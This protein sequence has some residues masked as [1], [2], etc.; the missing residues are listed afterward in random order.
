MKPINSFL[1]RNMIYKAERFL[2]TSIKPKREKVVILGCG[3]GGYRLAKDID[4][5]KFD[6]TLV[7]PRN[8]F[9]FTPLLPSTSV[10]TLEFRCIQEPIRAVKGLHYH[11]A[12][13][14]DLD[15]QAKT[16]TC[17]DYFNEGDKF[18]LSYDMLVV[19]TGSETNTFGVHGVYGNTSVF[20]LKQLSD[21][22]AIRNRLI[23]CFERASIPSTSPEEVKRLLTF[24][25][26]GGGPTNVEFAAE[27]HDFV[28]DDVE[29]LYPELA[30]KV[31]LTVIEAAGHILGAFTESLVG[32]VEGLFKSRNIEVLTGSLVQSVNGSSAVIKH[33]NTNTQEVLKFGLMVWST[34][35]QQIPLIREIPLEYK[36]KNGRLQIDEHLRLLK[37]SAS[38]QFTPIPGVYAIGDCAGHYEKPLAAL[39]Q[40]ANQQGRYLAQTVSTLIGVDTTLTTT[41]TTFNTTTSTDTT[42]TTTNTTTSPD[43]TLDSTTT[44]TTTDTNT[45]PPFK[46]AHLGSMASVGS[47]K[48]VLDT[49]GVDGLPDKMKGGLSGF[50]AFILWRAVYFSKQVSFTNMLLI[51][52]YWFKSAVLGRDISRF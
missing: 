18:T 19:S 4:K 46:Y 8:H 35:L 52:M 40:V 1:A 12:Y 44:D 37:T 33:N 20:F 16:V 42:T 11:Q 26:V 10:G 5:E 27:L 31:R 21:A 22:R 7:S 29:K 17:E 50:V 48:G 49:T 6:V 23:E 36:L 28:K 13:A 9:L 3:W 41:D 43:S 30:G 14:Q 34:G 15:F 51:P 2:A 32:Y 39:A 38:G 24:L 47:W 45:L 25:I